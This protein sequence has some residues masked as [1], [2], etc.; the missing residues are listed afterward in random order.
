[1]NNGFEN[2]RKNNSLANDF[3]GG[4]F[5]VPIVNICHNRTEVE[6]STAGSRFLFD[7]L[8]TVW[9]LYEQSSSH[10]YIGIA[11]LCDG[12]NFSASI[13]CYRFD[14]FKYEIV[15]NHSI[16]FWYIHEHNRSKDATAIVVV[17][18]SATNLNFFN[19][20]FSFICIRQ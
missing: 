14:R 9:S 8:Y 4:P 17:S 10:S 7:R 15:V 2:R 1:M 3:G 12:I 13:S 16:D 5:D 11:S 20:F 19:A 18:D 6:A